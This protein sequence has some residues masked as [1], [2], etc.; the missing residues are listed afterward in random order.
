MD[1]SLASIESISFSSCLFFD[2]KDS[3]FSYSSARGPLSSGIKFMILLRI[4]IAMFVFEQNSVIFKNSASF[5]YSKL[6]RSE[7]FLALSTLYS[8]SSMAFFFFKAASVFLFPSKNMISF[9]EFHQ[10]YCCYRVQDWSQIWWNGSSHR[11]SWCCSLPCSPRTKK[12]WCRRDSLRIL[13]ESAHWTETLLGYHWR[14]HLTHMRCTFGISFWSDVAFTQ[15]RNAF[16]ISSSRCLE[17][18]AYNLYLNFVFNWT[19]QA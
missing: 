16:Y 14:G 8:I 5:M 2:Q 7:L 11:C 4:L 19:Y 18:H 9:T 10:V 13:W 15:R 6:F 17:V 12:N 3:D 1:L